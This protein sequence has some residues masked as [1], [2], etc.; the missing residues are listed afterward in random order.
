MPRSL[1]FHKCS[2]TELL[3][4]ICDGGGKKKTLPEQLGWT[5]TSNSMICTSRKYKGIQD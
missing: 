5:N 3:I 4:K 2:I 1:G